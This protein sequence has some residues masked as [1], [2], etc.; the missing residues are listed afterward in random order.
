[1]AVDAPSVR[2]ERFEWQEPLGFAAGDDNLYRYVGNSSTNFTDPSGLEKQ[3][4]GDELFREAGKRNGVPEAI[5]ETIL[6]A[7]KSTTCKQPGWAETHNYCEKWAGTFADNLNRALN[8]MGL[9]HGLKDASGGGIAG[10]LDKTA[11][12]VPGSFPIFDPDQDHT[13]MKIVFKDGTT[14]YI[15]CST[16]SAMNVN[17]LTNGPSHIGLPEQI[18]PSWEKYPRKPKP[19]PEWRPPRSH[20]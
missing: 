13:A 7:A 16:I 8:A 9:K 10:P 17:N 6:N 4:N 2:C 15:D 14:F 5:I 12:F 11:W 1:V 20:W 18:P 3:K 19:Q